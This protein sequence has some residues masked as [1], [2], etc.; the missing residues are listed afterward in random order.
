MGSAAS[1]SAGFLIR[2]EDLRRIS[3]ETLKN[4]LRDEYGEPWA[5]D[6]VNDT[7]NP[8]LIMESLCEYLECYG[9]LGGDERRDRTDFLV[10]PAGAT[11][12]S[13]NDVISMSDLDKYQPAI[14]ALGNR[15]KDFLGITPSF[16]FMAS[17][18]E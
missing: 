6:F 16:V 5:P 11:C 1:I 2:Y 8:L 10:R 13:E 18:H 15:L 7:P 4:V 17:Y 3:P 9:L 12:L 14:L